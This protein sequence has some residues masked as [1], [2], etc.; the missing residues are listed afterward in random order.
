LLHAS[1]DSDLHQ[2]SIEVQRKSHHSLFYSYLLVFKA[3]TC[4]VEYRSLLD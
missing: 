1:P 3:M 2:E 4:D